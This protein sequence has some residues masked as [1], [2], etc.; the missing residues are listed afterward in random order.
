MCAHICGL[1]SRTEHTH[2]YLHTYILTFT[3]T[4]THMHTRTHADRGLH[5]HLWYYPQLVCD[6]FCNRRRTLIDVTSEYVC[7][8]SLAHTHTPHT[9]P[10][11]H[12]LTYTL[13]FHFHGSPHI[14]AHAHTTHMYTHNTHTY[15]QIHT[16][17]HTHTHTYTYVQIVVLNFVWMILTHS[18]TSFFSF[19]K[20]HPKSMY[21]CVCVCV[22]LR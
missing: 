11:T 10:L 4:H 2:S 14:H 1:V 9:H 8:F 3:H 20:M 6:L 17:T 5:T 19:R 18:R 22:W 21:V 15:T 12:P 13:V 7:V 16:H